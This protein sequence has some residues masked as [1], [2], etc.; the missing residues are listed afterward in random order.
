MERETWE[1]SF[2]AWNSLLLLSFLLCLE[3]EILLTFVIFSLGFPDP[4]VSRMKLKESILR[5]NE[6]GDPFSNKDWQNAV[7]LSIRQAV[8]VGGA[9][10]FVIQNQ[11]SD[12]SHP[13]HTPR[14]GELQRNL[15]KLYV[16]F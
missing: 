9:D 10:I 1:D 15:S 5:L 13:R 8:V 6:N 16:W 7:H 11:N 14:S 12:R 3:G 2:L 4:L